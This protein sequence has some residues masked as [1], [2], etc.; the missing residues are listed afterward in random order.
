MME[1]LALQ[2]NV[3]E[4]LLIYEGLRRLLSD[5]LGVSPSPATLA[6]HKRLLQGDT[7]RRGA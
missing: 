4:A 2:G 7:A 6:V 3:A 1:I 5:E